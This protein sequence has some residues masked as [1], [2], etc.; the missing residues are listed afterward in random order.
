M[1]EII[2]TNLFESEKS[3]Y[4]ADLVKHKSGKYY[5]NLKQSIRGFG[6]SLSEHEI[7]INPFVLN[8]LIEVLINYRDYL[9]EVDKDIDFHIP[10][11]KIDTLVERY[12]KGITLEDLSLQFD[13]SLEMIENILA[14]RGIPI[15]SNMKPSNKRN[16][17]KKQR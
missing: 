14:N 11:H 4:L 16:N 1:E 8:E 3:S 7:K 5:I 12:M 13:I 6:D 15:V 2:K 17:Y 10:Q 9:I